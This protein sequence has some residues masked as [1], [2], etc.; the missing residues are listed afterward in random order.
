MVA[1]GDAAGKATE[2]PVVSQLR[3][4]LSD[5]KTE[6]QQEF[7]VVNQKLDLLNDKMDAVLFKLGELRALIFKELPVLFVEAL[8]K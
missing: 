4:M 3:T 6:M 8:K 7:Q 2:N 1:F 5:L